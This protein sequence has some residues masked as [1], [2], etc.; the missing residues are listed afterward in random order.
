M[1]G[2][3]KEQDALELVPIKIDNGEDKAWGLVCGLPREEV[4]RATGASFDEAASAYVL[5]CYGR[6]FFVNPCDMLIA[7]A[8]GRGELLLGKLK[9]FF[10][11]AVLWYMSNAKDIPPTGRLLKPT[12]VKGGHRFT[13]GTHVLPLETIARRFARDREGFLRLGRLWGAEEL[14]GM[15]DACLRFLPLPRVPVTLV[16]WLEDEEFPPRV[17]LFFDSTCEFQLALS[18]VIWAV[19]MMTCVLMVDG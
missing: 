18:D 15:A 5:R 6:D 11:L 10:R 2:R 19:A 14:P 13:V 16:L 3:E 8:D 4:C 12:D 7:S 9:D 1:E 17:D